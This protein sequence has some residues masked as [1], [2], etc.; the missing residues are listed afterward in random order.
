MK[1]VLLIVLFFCF[2]FQINIKTIKAVPKITTVE[3]VVSCGDG[4]LQKES[5]EACDFGD[6]TLGV[7]MDFGT[8]TCSSFN[9]SFGN[10]FLSGFLS[11]EPDCSAVVTTSC[12]TCGNSVKEEMEACDEND[13]NGATCQSFGYQDG[14]LFC[15]D[16]CEINP[17]NCENHTTQEPQPG[18]SNTS[19]GSA[20]RSGGGA[21]GRDINQQE[22]TVIAIGNS[23]PHSEVRILQDGKVNGIVAADSKGDFYFEITGVTPGITTFSFWSQDEN[24]LKSTLL[25]VTFRVHGGSINTIS[26]VFISPTIDIDKEKVSSGDIINFFGKAIPKSQIDIH[27]HS[28]EEIIKEINSDE[29]GDWNLKF[30]T[31][32]LSEDFHTVKSMSKLEKNDS[33][34]SSNFSR[35][36]SFY[37]GREMSDE[38]KTADLNNDG[39]I[40][41]ADFSILLYHWNTDHIEADL[42]KDGHVDL[43]DFSIMMYSWTG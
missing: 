10:P 19:G 33:V 31:S 13:F 11:C 9:D 8:T 6:P 37:V 28:E 40:D 18:D 5:G 42:N 24:E 21:I 27:V 43:I 4:T 35:S 39:S 3:V 2:S 38:N 25:S 34:I 15:T 26:D 30:D 16:A 14:T 1:Y 32:I 36:V 23:Y 12:Y 29:K 7:P 22:T 20:G 17:N 41:L